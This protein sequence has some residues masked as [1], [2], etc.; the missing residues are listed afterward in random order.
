MFKRVLALFMLVSL[1]FL[2]QCGNSSHPAA[3]TVGPQGP[4]G[5]AGPAG[6]QGPVG[7]QGPQGPT[8]PQGPA[9]SFLPPIMATYGVISLAG[10][11]P[12]AVNGTSI[13]VTINE[14]QLFAITMSA[15]VIIAGGSSM[16]DSCYVALVENGTVLNTGSNPDVLSLG[17]SGSSN[18]QVSL[19]KT[20]FFTLQPGT[21]EW[22][23]QYTEPLQASPDFCQF[24]NNSIVGQSYGAGSTMQS[25]GTF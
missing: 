4:A 22:H 15:D 9:G 13:R 12:P 7:P 19:Q 8:G 17:T 23:L 11:N 18:L 5:P 21:Y 6:P 3:Q 24:T 16:G 2:L 14:A 1:A 10:N 25:S 20:V